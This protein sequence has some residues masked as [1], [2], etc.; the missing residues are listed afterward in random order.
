VPLPPT[1][2]SYVAPANAAIAQPTTLTLQWEGGPW[3][4][5]YDIYFGTSP[6]PPLYI[7]DV[8]TV[9][10]GAQPGQPLLDTGSVDDSNPE[11]YT[12][13]VTL[14]QGTI[15]YWRIVGK[16]MA[17]QTASGP[18]WSFVT[19]GSTAAPS[20]PS[21]LVATPISPTRIDL[22]WGDVGGETGYR[23]ERSS[24]GSSGWNEIASLGANQTTY[25]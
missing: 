1:Q 11:S 2:P 3:A 15:Y 7:A 22:S 23:V 24:D 8:S 18:T 10:S 13:P 5:K 20:A 17:N 9:Q 21:G 14:Q 16:T 12:I 4:H 19:L 6:N 25:S